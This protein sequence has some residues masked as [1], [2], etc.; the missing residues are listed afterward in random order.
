[1][2]WFKLY[3]VEMLADPKYQRLNAAERSCWITLLCLASLDDGNVRHCEESYLIGHSGIDPASNE[4]HK[5]HGVLMKFEML[6]M[7]ERA[8]DE[9]G[10]EYLIVKNWQKRQEHTSESYERV[11]KH[12][13]KQRLLAQS[14]DPVTVVTLQSNVRVEKSRVDKNRTEKPSEGVASLNYLKEVPQEDIAEFVTR[15]EVTPGKVKSIAEDLKLYCERKGKTYRNYK[16]SLINAIKRDCRER[17]PKLVE[18]PKEPERILT[19]AEKEAARIKREQITTS[20]RAIA[21]GKTI[22][23]D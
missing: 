2:Q 11:K 23:H 1:M 20:I 4:W 5:C 17:P 10:I 18:K 22:K 19:A 8:R 12:R 14:A 7:I 21:A 9:R 16:S 15:F 13:E 6:G 3:G